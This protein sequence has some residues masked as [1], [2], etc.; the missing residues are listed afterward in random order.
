M[1]RKLRGHSLI[2]I[3]RHEKRVPCDVVHAKPLS[4]GVEEI[5]IITSTRLD[6]FS[7]DA[8][9]VA[10]DQTVAGVFVFSSFQSIEDDRWL[11]RGI[12]MHFLPHSPQSTE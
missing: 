12:F 11:H 8:V 3:D 2:F 1:Q 9:H 5:H 7:Y 6:P 4:N 10:P